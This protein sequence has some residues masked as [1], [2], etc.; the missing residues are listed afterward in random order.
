MSGWVSLTRKFI[1]DVHYQRSGL[2]IVCT[3]EL[4]KPDKSTSGC[5]RRHM[6]GGVE[7][8]GCHNKIHS[9]F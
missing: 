9:L 2:P 4:Q 7:E 8:N 6:G 3:E 1:V 5:G